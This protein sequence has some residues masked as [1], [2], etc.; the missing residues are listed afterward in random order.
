MPRS[1]KLDLTQAI[2]F[3]VNRTAYMMRQLARE[4]FAELGLAL[5]PEELA[6]LAHLWQEDGRTQGELADCSI[7]DRT[8]V[9]R[10]LDRMSKKGLVRREPG[11]T[12][13]RR[14]RAWLTEK[15]KKLEQTVLPLAGG[16][17]RQLTAG[18]PPEEMRITLNSLRRIQ[19]NIASARLTG[20][21]RNGKVR[22]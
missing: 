6:L 11:R 2:G 16:R 22:S 4:T 7:R 10:I 8:T 14:V 12:D 5:T 9:T 20:G 13:R 15:G 1:P 19:R 21:A 18:I 17:L 3:V